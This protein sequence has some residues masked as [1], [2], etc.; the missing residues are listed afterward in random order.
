M[1]ETPEKQPQP[2]QPNL[3]FYKKIAISVLIILISIFLVYGVS[4]QVFKPTEDT[5]SP[6]QKIFTKTITVKALSPT[7]SDLGLGIFA[8]DGNGYLAYPNDANITTGEKNIVINGTYDITYYNEERTQFR[9]ITYIE[10]NLTI[11]TMEV[12]NNVNISPTVAV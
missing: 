6:I 7:G 8:T 2:Q 10:Q 12:Q 11:K 5:T 3:I 9:I 1:T 4:V